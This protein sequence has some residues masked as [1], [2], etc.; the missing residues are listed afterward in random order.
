MFA[1][2]VYVEYLLLSLL[3]MDIMNPLNTKPPF[4]F[5][6]F[7]RLTLNNRHIGTL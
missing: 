2:S 1:F 7:F 5:F 6:S 3:I 4:F